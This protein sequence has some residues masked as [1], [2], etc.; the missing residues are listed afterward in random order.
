M[1]NML[2]TFNYTHADKAFVKGAK[3]KGFNWIASGW[4]GHNLR[5]PDFRDDLPV[6]FEKY[7]RVAEL[8]RPFFPQIEEQI[9]EA[10]EYHEEIHRQGLKV[11]LFTYEP[12]VP[13]EMKEAYPELFYSYPEEYTRLD[14]TKKDTKLMCIFD[15]RVQDWLADKCEELLKN[16]GPV[17]AWIY[18]SNETM[19]FSGATNHICENCFDEPRWK[20]LRLVRDAM[21][22]GVDRLPYKVKLIHRFWGSHHPREYKQI[23]M[24]RLDYFPSAPSWDTAKA[25][26]LEPRSY[27]CDVDLPVFIKTLAEEPERACVV[28]KPT[29]TD[30]LLHQPYNPWMGYSRDDVDEI[31]E[32]S[33]EPCH[34]EMYGFIPCLF[35]KQLQDM[36]RYSLERGIKG[37]CI[38]PVEFDKDWGVNQANLDI[39]LQVISNPDADVEDLLQQWLNKRYDTEISSEI[40]Q[41][42]LNSEDIWAELISYNGIS[43]LV[44]FDCVLYPTYHL[45]LVTKS[46]ILPMVKTMWKD[47]KERFDLTMEGFSKAI[48]TWNKAANQARE[49]AENIRQ[50][51]DKLPEKAY[52]ELS[53]FF[54]RLAITTLFANYNQK[55][56][57]MRWSLEEGLIKPT[58]QIMRMIEHWEGHCNYIIAN[59]RDIREGFVGGLGNS[60]VDAINAYL[61]EDDVFDLKEEKTLEQWPFE[62][63]EGAVRIM[64]GVFGLHE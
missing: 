42:L 18:S 30:F 59:D 15:Q 10:R 19:W 32:L 56:I 47:G 16:V 55:L 27:N 35:I 40:V 13:V 57:F 12:S 38:M 9:T 64:T 1:K 44:N 61:S 62:I 14:P 29:W 49:A 11:A 22:R 21:Q 39:T 63:E 53:Y 2:L 45:S 28:S 37:V 58:R 8:R 24:T 17:D 60:F 51:K 48:R 6:Y 46:Y 41:H 33:I 25:K 36:Y 31:A 43:G 26:V 7:E 50:Y 20:A 3:E 54:E 4:Y 34:Q 23:N 5:A 52:K